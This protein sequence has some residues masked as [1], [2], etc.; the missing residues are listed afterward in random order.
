MMVQQK[1]RERDRE[2]KAQPGNNIRQ[3]ST[4]ATAAKLLA[5]AAVESSGEARDCTR[6]AGEEWGDSKALMPP[7]AMPA[8]PACL[9]ACLR[10]FL[11]GSSSFLCLIWRAAWEVG[12]SFS[13]TRKVSQQC[14]FAS[15]SRGGGSVDDI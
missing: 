8:S 5:P 7:H 6:A 4:A 10:A 14:L 3:D 1:E 9:Y 2:K 11:D 13:M 12:F 15:L